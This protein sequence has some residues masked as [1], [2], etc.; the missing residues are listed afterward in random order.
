M[1][2]K[3]ASRANDKTQVTFALPRDPATETACVC[4]DWDD[5]Q[6]KHTMHQENGDWKYILELESGK[7][8]QFRYLVN[9]EQWLND[10]NAD[11]HVPN[12]FGSE[13]FVV[14]T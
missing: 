2:T 9:G 1:I 6:P 7:E 12:P 14:V 13:N 10:P 11:K 4:G 5:W 8:Y 3:D